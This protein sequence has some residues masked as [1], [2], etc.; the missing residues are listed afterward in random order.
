MT[1]CLARAV[2]FVATPQMYCAES[3]GTPAMIAG[4]KITNTKYTVASKGEK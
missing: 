1:G 2:G 3:L 4:V